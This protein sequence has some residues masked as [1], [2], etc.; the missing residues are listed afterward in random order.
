MNE[1]NAT[2]SST[3]GSQQSNFTKKK[4]ILGQNNDKWRQCQKVYASSINYTHIS[5]KVTEGWHRPF[6]TV[7]KTTWNCCF[8]T[9]PLLKSLPTAES[10]PWEN[11]NGITEGHPGAQRWLPYVGQ[12]QTATRSS[13]SDYN[14]EHFPRQRFESSWEKLDAHFLLVITLL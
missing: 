9:P 4:R 6:L 1:A 14:V 7:T 2:I 5:F 11:S 10:C 8:P 13:A 3:T 12:K